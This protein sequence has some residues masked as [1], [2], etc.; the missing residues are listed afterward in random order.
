MDWL[1][2][3]FSNVLFG[4][5]ALAGTVLLWFSLQQERAPIGVV[6]QAT[7]APAVAGQAKSDI[8]IQS[9]TVKAYD[10][11]AKR[12]VSLP[13][14]VQADPHKNVIESSAVPADDHPQTV[15]SVI[16]TQTGEIETFV[17][18][19]PLPLF[20]LDYR[21][22][23]GLYLGFRNGYGAI[24]AEARQAIFSVKAVHF[25]VIGSVESALGGVPSPPAAF[26]GGGGWGNWDLRD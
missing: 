1:K 12:K 7:P 16:D 25:G 4:L 9:G 2:R 26:I 21:G 5:A 14:A 24:R 10:L 20:A 23:A 22:D 13:G 11:S 3:N 8:P 15:T 18:R 17:I 19:E 6:T